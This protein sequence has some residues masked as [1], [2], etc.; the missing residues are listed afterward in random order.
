MGRS[1]L[2]RAVDVLGDVV[3]GDDGGVQRDL[4]R[5]LVLGQVG[6]RLVLHQQA[7]Q[8]DA[9]RGLGG[10]VDDRRLE[11]GV[12]DWISRMALAEPAPPTMKNSL[13]LAFL[14]AARTP[15]PWSSSWFQM[16]SMC[17][18]AWSRFEAASSPDS[19][20]N[21]AATRLLTFSPQSASASAKP[22]LR[23]WVRGSESMP[24]I[25]ATT[26][27]GLSPSREQT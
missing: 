23:S 20:V 9:V 24:A 21:S 11:D 22:L 8:A 14:T 5:H 6:Q 10:R 2:E 19:T 12:A 7:G 15:T 3:L 18:A 26:A 4:A 13:R 27:F 1:G 25:S 17:G 16:A